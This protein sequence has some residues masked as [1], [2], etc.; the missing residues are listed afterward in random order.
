MRE[1]DG[2]PPLFFNNALEEALQKNI[3]INK[4]IQIRDAQTEQ[5]AFDSREE[6]F[7]NFREQSYKWSKEW[8]LH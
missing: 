8:A 2:L 3:C 5:L 6:R 4:G 7:D 1:G